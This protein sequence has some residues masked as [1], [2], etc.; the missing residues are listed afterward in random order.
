MRKWHPILP[1]ETVAEIRRLY[2]ADRTR[3]QLNGYLWKLYEAGW[4]QES[5]AQALLCSRQS[6]WQRITERKMSF[7][8][9]PPI[10]SVPTRPMPDP[11]ITK[12][13]PTVDPEILDKLMQMHETA[14]WVNGATP[15]DHPSRQVS[16][17][18]SELLAE[19]VGKGITPG[20]I[21]KAMGINSSGIYARLARH[22]YRKSP[23]SQE[24]AVYKGTPTGSR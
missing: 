19:L 15:A 10:P 18:Y 23:P 11:R 13:R 16:V 4:P 3:V 7:D 6:I 5:M 1:E 21:G 22:G 17:E 9:L 24:R 12:P 14:R 20:V 2:F 8:N